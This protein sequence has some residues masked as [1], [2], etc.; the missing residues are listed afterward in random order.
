MFTKA[1][2]DTINDAEDVAATDTVVGTYLRPIAKQL[3]SWQFQ[4]AVWQCD[5]DADSGELVA[6]TESRNSEILDVVRT[7]FDR[8]ST[9]TK[10]VFRC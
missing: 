8:E 7:G 2:D 1:F 10:Q 5:V 9:V 3:E 4:Y 6:S